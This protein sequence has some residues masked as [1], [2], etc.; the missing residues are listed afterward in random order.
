M[1]LISALLVGLAALSTAA[2][3]PASHVVHEKRDSTPSRWVNLGRVQPN[4]KHIMRVG[5][6][7]NNIDKA[8]EYLM[9]VSHPSSPNYGKHWTPEQVI[10]AFAPSDETVSSVRQWLNEAGIADSRITHTENKGWLAFVAT[11]RELEGLLHTEFYNYKDK[12]SGNKVVACE[13]YAEE[14]PMSRCNG[15][16]FARY[17]VPQQI[18]QHIDFI[19]PGILLAP[20]KKGTSV[21]RSVKRSAGSRPPKNRPVMEAPP[22]G[23]ANCDKLITPECIKALYKIPPAT[24]A[25]PNNSL[26]IFEE[27]D[28][29]SQKDL[30]L[31]FANMSSHIP[32]GTH[33]IPAF[34]DGAKAPV[35]VEQAG[36]ESDLDFELAYPI[37]YPQN[38]TLYQTDD[39]LYALTSNY[40]SGFFNTFLDAID[41]VSQPNNYF[42]VR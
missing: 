37:V 10:E 38:I 7:Q 8:Y 26:G 23:L 29:Y 16:T 41:G 21:E 39:L 2:S 42:S 36:G 40:T 20:S 18:Q 9:D 6:K 14:L 31:F 33:P 17:H 24:K 34:I 3:A 27:G 13:Q 19:K 1:R 32:Q 12:S 30:D 15:L 28:F 5:L 4:S 11:G 35:S 22:P 25:H